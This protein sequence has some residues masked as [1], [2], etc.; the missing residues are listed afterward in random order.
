MIKITLAP[1]PSQSF[2]VVLD[3]Q[4]C[5]I[6]LYQ[7]GKRMYLDLLADD[8]TIC[9]GAICVNRTEIVQSPSQYFTGGLYFYD[10]KGDDAPQW[11]RL[12]ERFFLIFVPQ[13]EALPLEFQP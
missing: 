3:G 11:D 12:E 13:G 7:R 2:Q 8:Q 1:I 10:A 9:Q 4:Y 6:S 5:A